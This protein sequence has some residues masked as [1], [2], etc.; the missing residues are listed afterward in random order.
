VDVLEGPVQYDKYCLLGQKSISP[1]K[2]EILQEKICMVD[3]MVNFLSPS[4]PHNFAKNNRLDLKMS[5]ID[6][7]RCQLQYAVKIRV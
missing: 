6:V 3:C 7:S 4:F 1:H 2:L 5:C